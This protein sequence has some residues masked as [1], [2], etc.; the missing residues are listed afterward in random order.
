MLEKF[1]EFILSLPMG[2]ELLVC[3]CG[4]ALV[5]SVGFVF[6]MFIGPWLNRGPQ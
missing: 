2:L 6:W 3:A 1:A 5:F 4:F